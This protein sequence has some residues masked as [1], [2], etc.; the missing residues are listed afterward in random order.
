M[1]LMIQL[2]INATITHLQLSQSLKDTC[3]LIM[4]MI[5]IQGGIAMIHSI[6]L[7]LNRVKYLLIGY[8]NGLKKNECATEWSKL[9]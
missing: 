3:I 2:P 1:K 9:N 6:K 7:N 8:L 5:I 4:K